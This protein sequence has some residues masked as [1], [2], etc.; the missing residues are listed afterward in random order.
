MEGIIERDA[1][2]AIDYVCQDLPREWAPGIIRAEDVDALL[3]ADDCIFPK[4][5]GNFIP[6][7]FILLKA[8]KESLVVELFSVD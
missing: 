3:Y 2:W 6:W 4:E 5:T 8:I 1:G 7:I